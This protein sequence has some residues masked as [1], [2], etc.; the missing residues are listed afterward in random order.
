MRNMDLIILIQ[1][2]EAIEAVIG[3]SDYFCCRCNW[4][5]CYICG[6]YIE[7]GGLLEFRMSR[8]GA[9]TTSV[10]VVVDADALPLP[11]NIRDVISLNPRNIPF[12]RKTRKRDQEIRRQPHQL[13]IAIHIRRL[14][15]WCLRSRSRIDDRHEQG[16]LHVH[17]A[18][19]AKDI[20]KSL[21][22]DVV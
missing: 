14:V 2:G 3:N 16:R 12:R 5:R 19:K 4:P 20:R 18:M 15:F 9:A 13:T 8:N 1:V 7:E 10:Q 11:V 22:D 17:R 21:L 6:N